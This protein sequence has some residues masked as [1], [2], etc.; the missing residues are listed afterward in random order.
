MN[1]CTLS[2]ARLVQTVWAAARAHSS[3]KQFDAD[4]Y[5]R[6]WSGVH[7][8]LDPKG[9]GSVDID[10][11]LDLVQKAIHRSLSAAASTGSQSE[12]EDGCET[13]HTGA[14]EGWETLTLI[15]WFAVDQ[16]ETGEMPTSRFVAWLRQLA[17][18]TV[19]PIRQLSAVYVNVNHGC[20][21]KLAACLLPLAMHTS[22]VLA[23]HTPSGRAC[24]ALFV[25][26][27]GRCAAARCADTCSIAVSF[28]T[29]QTVC[30]VHQGRVACSISYSEKGGGKW[31]SQHY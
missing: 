30:V 27:R 19:T 4:A 28:P 15:I 3:G 16:R 23:H 5:L 13:V 1:G 12:E 11:W 18:A 7:T 21:P 20:A 24:L 25:S 10:T 17:S 9:V 31:Q 14:V 26:R 29:P 2:A 8:R 22:S 6:D